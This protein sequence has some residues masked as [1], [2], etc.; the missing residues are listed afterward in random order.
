MAD[1]DT[2]LANL[3]RGALPESVPARIRNDPAFI[4]TCARTV[5]LAAVASSARTPAV[6]LLALEKGV[7]AD[8]WNVPDKVMKTHYKEIVEVCI[9]KGMNMPYPRAYFD[10]DTLKKMVK[11][12]S[13]MSL[14]WVDK[15]HALELRAYAF[16]TCGA[17]W[18]HTCAYERTLHTPA[19][20]L[21]ALAAGTPAKNM[22]AHLVPLPVVATELAAGK[23]DY[24]FMLHFGEVFTEAMWCEA[25]DKGVAPVATTPASLL[26]EDYVCNAIARSDCT[27]ADVPSRL[28]TPRVVAA[29]DARTAAMKERVDRLVANHMAMW[30]K[31]NPTASEEQ[32]EH[33]RTTYQALHMSLY[34]P[35]Q[36]FSVK[37]HTL[38]ADPA[39]KTPRAR[40]T[41]APAPTPTPSTKTPRGPPRVRT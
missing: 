29:I 4:D 15:K 32:Q 39:I 35:G 40:T 26:T 25:M 2:Y 22:P 28:H 34:T 24:G 20:V 1:H 5:G 23:A 17:P 21:K 9:R 14:S 41:P 37:R 10:M 30:T 11:S 6:C 16:D 8:V 38:K 7:C 36:H 19:R 12:D 27:L 13:S 18:N 33:E 31:T 3:V